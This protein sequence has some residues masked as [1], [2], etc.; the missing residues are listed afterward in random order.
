MTLRTRHMRP[1]AV[2]P[3]R[4]GLVWP[5]AL[6]PSGR[7][8]PTEAQARGRG[9][10]RATRGLYVPADLDPT[11]ATDQR[12]VTAAAL[13]PPG[14]AL[15]GWAAL[16]WSGAR[17]LDGMRGRVDLPVPLAVPPSSLRPRRGVRLTEA[18]YLRRALVE[19]DGLTLTTP[20][21]STAFEV[22]HAPSLVDA[23]AV[24]DRAC[25]ADLVSLAEME[26]WTERLA[27]ARWVTRLRTTIA[28]ADENCW[29]PAE[30]AMR[31]CWLD[32]G[33]RT[34]VCNRPVFDLEGRFLGTPD[35][36]DLEL[37]V[38]GEYDGPLH[39]A[40][41]Q[42]AKDIRREGVFRR[43]G[44]EYVEMVAADLGDTTDF[45]QRT[46]DARQRARAIPG[47]R[48]WTATPP[49]G[50]VST[51][52]VARRRAL[53]PWQRARFLRWQREH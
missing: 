23:V 19:V 48:R 32:I 35:L 36:L 7:D 41:Q 6:D 37:G 47:V 38:A 33:I 43:A 5:V 22:L 31:L 4:P 10:V 29:S 20:C 46:V 27:G 53:T 44:L 49:D 28:L 3:G 25:A 17:H 1:P 13:L 52:T 16:R 8:G 45:I 50:W 30:T 11:L 12:I 40:G 9:W 18:A 2:G 42:R 51:H 21:A 14:G 34:I 15:T 26:A 24:V 39:L